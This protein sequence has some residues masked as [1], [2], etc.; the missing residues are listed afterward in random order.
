MIEYV[1]KKQ[2]GTTLL[3]HVMCFSG[4]GLSEEDRINPASQHLPASGDRPDAEGAC[5]RSVDT[6]RPQTG[7]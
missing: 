6:G 1:Y 7:H 4:E 3:L 5:C 2:L